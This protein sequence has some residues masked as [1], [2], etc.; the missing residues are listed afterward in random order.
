MPIKEILDRIL[1]EL[2]GAWRFRWLGLAA[3]WV[4]CLLG[5]FYIYTIPDSYQASATVY[6]DSRGILRP[7]LQGLAI[8]PDVASGLDLVRQVLLS[9]PQ[10]EQVARETGLD[11]MA[12]TPE[13]R[14]QLVRDIQS[15]I[16]IEAG[17]LRARTTQGEGLYRISFHDNDREKSIR[18]VQTMLNGFVENALGDKRTGQQSAQKF[19]DEQIA[20][21]EARLR[22]SEERLADF[23]KKNVGMMPN[24]EGDYF[25]KLQTETAGLDTVRTNLGVAESRRDEIQ[26]QL[27]GEEPYLFGIDSGNSAATQASG[28]GDVAYRIQEL[29]SKLED[30]LLRYTDKHPEVIATRAMIEELKKKQD[31]ELAR[32][33][34]GESATGSLSSS[35]KTNPVYQSLQIELKNTQVHIAELRRELEERQA[36]VNDLRS[37]VNTV[38]EVEAELA[39]LNRDYEVNRQQYQ[40]LAQRRET[41]SLSEDAD[42]SGTVSFKTIEPP[43]AAFKPV[44]P[45]RPKLLAAVLVAGLGLAAGVSWLMNQLNP[46]F[47]NAKSLGEITGVQVIAAVSRTWRE[48]HRHLRRVQLLRFTAGAGL[49]IAIFGAAV[50]LQHAGALHLQ[51]LLG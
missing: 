35:L 28:G 41:A 38:P 48:R 26:R 22:A 47:N 36:H 40:E 50:V 37:K 3:A 8:D 20:T 17:D 11:T 5:W 30:L 42:K 10:I 34:K 23:K 4:V 39:R 19:L 51:R 9:R 24:S 14:A 32:V 46:V 43:A 13:Q 16:S 33:H 21:Y 49:L 2:R 6:V 31:E 15:R 25:A 45:N 29:Q 12:K 18:V 27:N 1:D 7:L 44:S